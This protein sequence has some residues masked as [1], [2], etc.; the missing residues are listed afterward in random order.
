MFGVRKAGFLCASAAVAGG[1]AYLVWNYARSSS[2]SSSSSTEEEKPGTRDEE[3]REEQT[4]AAEA[5]VAPTVLVLGLDGAGKTSLLACLASGSSEADVQP[6]AVSNAVSIDRA[7][8]RLDFLEIGG[9][10]ELRPSWR[11][12]V[13]GARALVFVVDSSD[14][15][16]FPLARRHLHELLA[17]DPRLPLMVLANKQDLPG[18]GG[19][20]DL[21]EALALAEVGERR[22]FVISTYA[23]TGEAE[24]SSGVADARE[25]IGQLVRDG[26]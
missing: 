2:S 13:S 17:S 21:C 19:T 1:A 20:A 5:P 24:L 8:L 10:E 18:A 14:P 25:L 3:R 26:G 9:R 6:T 11:R 22:L 7:G 23:N 4:V 12:Y 15:Q 16:R